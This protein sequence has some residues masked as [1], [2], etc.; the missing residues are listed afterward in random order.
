M[1]FIKKPN[2]TKD[3]HFMVDSDMLEQIYETADIHDGETIVEIGGGEGALTDY[4]SRG[5]NVVTVIEKDPYYANYLKEKYKN[6][7][8][9]VVIEGDALKFDFSEFDRIVAN[10]P[11][12]ITE[13]FLVNLASSGALNYG[14]SSKDSNLKSI[15]LV[16]SQNS[17][18][19]MF[20][21]IQ[22][23]EN[24][25]KYFNHEFGKMGAIC[26]AFTDVEIITPIP[27][28][29][30][31]PQPAV[32][33]FLVNLKPTKAKTTVDRILREMFVDK[34]GK[35]ASIKE[36]YQTLI[37]QKGFYKINKYNGKVGSFDISFSS[38]KIE[39]LNIYEL[40]NDQLSTLIQDLIKN[41]VRI[42][43]HNQNNMNKQS[44][45]DGYIRPGLTCKDYFDQFGYHT[46]DYEDVYE[47]DFEDNYEDE[48]LSNN[49]GIVVYTDKDFA[50]YDGEI[51][52]S[53]SEYDNSETIEEYESRNLPVTKKEKNILAKY[54]K[55]YDSTVYEFL[56]Q[57]GLEYID[58]PFYGDKREKSALPL[59]AKVLKRS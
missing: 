35:G 15:T 59:K 31:N 7:N 18:R 2:P 42:K 40:N 32:T 14:S 39:N 5:A 55:Y 45:Y 38:K 20:A 1:S 28:E 56:L 29:A 37:Y 16:L 26:K 9:V 13:D 27:S 41:D 4:L 11:Y 33:S 47:D 19:K 34:K 44:S 54:E 46:D 57:R 49:S 8:N 53:D 10:L 48:S 50:N 23:E 36:V 21:P 58:S 43:T 51:D 6:K 30:F 17:V 24:G 12:T 3:Q 25:A 22:L 52:Y